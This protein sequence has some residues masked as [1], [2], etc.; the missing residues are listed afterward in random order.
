[1]LKKFQGITVED[2][3]PRFLERDID[4]S[5]ELLDFCT[6]DSSHIRARIIERNKNFDTAPFDPAGDKFRFYPKGFTIWSGHAGKG[7]T[8]LLRQTVCHLLNRGRK[9]FVASL[10]EDPVEIIEKL[11]YVA[12]GNGELADG[13]F[14]YCM[15]HWGKTLRIWG[16]RRGISGH[17]RILAM[18]RVLA[19][20]DGITHAVIDSL[21]RLD[22]ESGDFEGQRRFAAAIEDTCA[23][24]NLHIHLVAHPRKPN[25]PG[26][27]PDTSDIAG[28]S[29]LG[30]L[31][32]NVLFV[33]RKDDDTGVKGDISP[34]SV[35]IKKQRHYDGACL[36]I[37]GHFN[38]R[39]RQWKPQEWDSDPTQYLPTGAY[40]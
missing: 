25:K 14:D 15:E 34:M 22:I 31:A 35:S 3:D 21:A 38:R 29:D 17:A 26:Q 20:Q 1:M 23:G 39:L 33:R 30:R 4:R 16:R 9:V 6:I 2:D 8:T 10:E 40:A 28:S 5:A 24:S 36:P 19:E 18:I 27:E 12:Y 7:K 37:D 11:S 13:Q 32:D